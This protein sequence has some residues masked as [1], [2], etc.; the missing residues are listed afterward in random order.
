MTMDNVFVLMY[1]CVQCIHFG[2]KKTMLCW[3]CGYTNPTSGK[4]LHSL[5]ICILNFYKSSESLNISNCVWE[6]HQ[7]AFDCLFFFCFE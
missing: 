4:L 7:L 3:M 1:V 5:V 6:T 2:S